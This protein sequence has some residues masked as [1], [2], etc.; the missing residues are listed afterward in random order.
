[1][2]VYVCVS[3]KVKWNVNTLKEALIK[4]EKSK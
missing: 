4:E 3:I 1:M 2:L